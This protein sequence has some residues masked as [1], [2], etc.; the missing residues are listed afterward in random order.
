MDYTKLSGPIIGAIIG[1]GTNWIAIKMLF[2][3][4]KPVKIGKFT[5]PF[6][7]GII[8]KRQGKIA[9]AIGESIANNLFTENDI[10]EMLLDENIKDEV[11]NSIL[12]KLKDEKTFEEIIHEKIDDD[13]Y[14]FSREKIK[15][16]ITKKV[17]DGLI[18]ANIGEIIANEGKKIVSEKTKGSM[19]RMFVTDNMIDSMI[20]PLGNSIQDYI[21]KHGEE[22]IE[23]K[24]DEEICLIERSSSKELFEKFEIDEDNLKKQ[25]KELFEDFVNNHISNFLQKIDISKTIENKINEMEVAELEQIL[26]SIMKKELGAIVNL[27]AYIGLILGTLNVFI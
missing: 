7:P 22:K 6:T 3:P 16:L 20:L 13:Q 5:L 21:E 23:P 27:G 1:Y 25:I 26:L 11:A 10:K 19:L 8:P 24:I 17:K 15:N 14:F 9:K 2:R 4:L 18:E 12:K